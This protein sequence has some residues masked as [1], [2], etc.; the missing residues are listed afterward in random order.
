M[1]VVF[2][3]EGLDIPIVHR[4]SKVHEKDNRD[5]K[6]LTKGDNNEVDDRS[7]Y[8]EGQNWVK[9]DMVGRSKR[10]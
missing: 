6:I 4:V 1:T 9:K 8:K 5:I 7:L 10:F 2:K 3:V